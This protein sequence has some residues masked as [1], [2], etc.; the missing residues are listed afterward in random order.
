M[1]GGEE[2]WNKLLTGKSSNQLM[3]IL[4]DDINHLRRTNMSWLEGRGCGFREAI[5][6]S[7][8][9]IGSFSLLFYLFYE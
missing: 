2:R 3:D 1:E 5:K 9:I 7:R 6:K 4:L 8:K